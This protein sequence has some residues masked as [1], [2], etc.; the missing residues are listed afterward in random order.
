MIETSFGEIPMSEELAIM[1]REQLV[2]VL[3]STE[4]LSH[5]D[6]ELGLNSAISFKEGQRGVAT[7]AI[8]D[9]EHQMTSV[10]LRDAA[11]GVHLPGAFYEFAP[12]E[13]LLYNL[14]Y[15][16]SN[17]NGKLRL[18]LQNGNVVGATPGR[19]K[20]YSNLELIEEVEKTIGEGDILG[21]HQA[22][23]N[24]GYSR[25]GV[26]ADRSFQPVPDDTLYGGIHFENSIIGEKKIQISPYIFR[27]WCANGA[28]VQQNISQWSRRNDGSCDIREW[29]RS[30]TEQAL[31]SLDTEFVRIRQLTETSIEG[32]PVEALR[33]L[34]VKFGIPVRTQQE[35]ISQAE[36]QNGGNGPATMYDLW[37]SMTWVATHS[38]KISTS[39]SV[40]LQNVAGQVVREIDLCPECHQLVSRGG[41]QSSED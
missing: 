17:S 1:N 26:V 37:N 19:C 13:L 20:Y 33:S 23:T 8:K 36:S 38:S 22:S 28:I 39:G 11:R 30:S 25:L 40:E 16:Y 34:F 32:H 15:L 35:I 7:I 29:V 31:R 2:N 4:G 18:F 9:D 12:Q 21:F 14:N 6:V 3:A 10:G 41:D 5:I 27:Q 24:L